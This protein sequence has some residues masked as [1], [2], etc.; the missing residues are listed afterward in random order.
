[1]VVGGACRKEPPG[2][3][4]EVV[5]VVVVVPVVVVPVVIVVVVI[6]SVLQPQVSAPQDVQSIDGFIQPGLDQNQEG[7]Q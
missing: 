4:E 5:I 2:W 7:Q 3:N 6:S 1:M